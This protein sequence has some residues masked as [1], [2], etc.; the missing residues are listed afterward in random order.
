MK[1]FPFGRDTTDMANIIKYFD[2]LGVSIKFIDDG[3]STEGSMG[4]MIDNR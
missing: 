2:E 3:I 1:F 4:K